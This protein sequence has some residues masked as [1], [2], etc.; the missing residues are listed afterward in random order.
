[1]L[2]E[3]RASIDVALRLRHRLVPYL[4][5]MN[6][7]AAT[8]GLP[9]VRPMYHVH[10]DAEQAYEVPNQYAFGSELIVAPI[11][12]P[13]DPVT[14]LGA[15]H[16]WLPEGVWIDLT[17]SVAYDGGRELDL[18]RDDASIPVLLRAG[19]ILPLASEEA[20]DA[21]ENPASLEIVVAPGADGEFTLIEDDGSGST[22]KEMLTA[23]TTI[24]WRQADGLVTIGA[25]R[26]TAGIVPETRT[27]TV[28]LLAV[29]GVTTVTIDGEPQAV[30]PVAG[31]VSVIVADVASDKPT[32]IVFGTDHVPRTSD[33]RERLFTLLN[34]AQH[35]YEAKNAIW[36][37]L[38]RETTA[39]AQLAELQSR[40]VP[41]ALLSAI[42]ELLT[43]R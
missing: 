32:R 43:A 8:D 22:P 13:H 41:V 16:V 4:H 36:A 24:S 11:T 18:H 9:L 33:V 23:R 37:T 39:A 25:A 40:A 3:A 17:T 38:T 6:H 29:H 31:R 35:D 5:T 42:A 20:L 10:P 14:L 26:G 7:R 28:T 1:M 19:G 21:T 30:T 12:S 27:W 34:R 15:A 2:T